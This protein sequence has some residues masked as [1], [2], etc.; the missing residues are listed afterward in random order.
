[1]SRQENLGQRNITLKKG[2]KHAVRSLDQAYQDVYTGGLDIV[3]VKRN[4]IL[5]FGSGIKRAAEKARDTS[6]RDISKKL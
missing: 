1:L 3:A 5:E 6:I 4:S 2:L